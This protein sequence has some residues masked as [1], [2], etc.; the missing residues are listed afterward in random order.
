MHDITKLFDL[1]DEDIIIDKV[2]IIDDQKLIYISKKLYPTYCPICGSRMYSRG[3]NKRLINHPVLQDGYK[4][5]LVFSQRK[6]KCTNIFCKYICNDYLN[7]I[8]PFKHSTTIL[9]YLIMKELKNINVTISSAAKRL[10]VSDT[11]VYYTFLKYVN[12]KRLPLSE[13]I[14]IDEV[15]LNIDGLHKYAMVI[16]NFT[17]GQIIDIVESRRERDSRKFFNSISK[18]EREKVKYIIS[19][20]YNPYLNFTE[21]YFPNSKSVID[22]FHVIKWINGKINS[23][24]NSIKA[25]YLKLDN[26]KKQELDY[27]ENRITKSRKASK[28]VYLLTKYKWIIMSAKKNIVYNMEPKYN[29][30]LDQYLTIKQ[31]EEMVMKLDCKFKIYVDL[32]ELYIEFND[33]GTKKKDTLEKDFEN[34][35]KTYKESEEDIFI[36][37]AGLLEKYKEEILRSFNVVTYVGKDSI[38]EIRRLSN[39]PM[40]SFNNIPKDLKRIS[41]GLSRFDY[42]RARILLYNRTESA[43]LAVPKEDKAVR[44]PTGKKR[45]SYKKQSKK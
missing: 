40:E 6:W 2:E 35:I 13:V 4:L 18:E 21:R 22:S 26:M 1:V 19:D 25:K 39:G 36:E 42:A 37:F 38:E 9:P 10:N 27:R 29:R 43:M 30:F 16:M 14:S 12:F 3:I 11:T 23:Y 41:N 7:F 32:R 34:I 24:I 31:I 8:E 28:E 17:N 5:I 44:I 20:I 33:S 15:F 45:G